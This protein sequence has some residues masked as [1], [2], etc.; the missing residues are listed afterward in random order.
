MAIKTQCTF[1]SVRKSSADVKYKSLLLA[2][3]LGSVSHAMFEKILVL[4]FVVGLHQASVDGSAGL[5]FSGSSYAEYDPWSWFPNATLQFFFQTSTSEQKKALLFY[6]DDAV[7]GTN[8]YFMRLFLT[9]SGFAKFRA[10]LG[11][12][13]EE[14]EIK[15]NFADSQWHKV[16][17]KIDV[18]KV[19]LSIKDQNGVVHTAEPPFEISASA[20]TS[21]YNVLF[22]AGIPLSS[23]PHRDFSDTKLFG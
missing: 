12:R 18:K 3:S 19:H 11:P 6:Q 5:R 22:I 21:A 17:I 8:Y 16:R 2:I 9:S 15:H 14:S 4:L 10:R 13:T 1:L 23:S 20:Q 7:K